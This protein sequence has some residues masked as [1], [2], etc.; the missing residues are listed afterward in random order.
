MNINRRAFALLAAGGALALATACGGTSD[1]AASG[2]A[3]EAATGPVTLNLWTWTGAPGGAAMQRAIDA[4]TKDHPN[5]TIKNTEIAQLDFKAKVP[6]ALNAGE[7]IDVLAVQ[8]NLFAD[9]IKDQLLPV[10]A[11]EKDLPAGTMAKFQPLSLEQNKK[12]YS[13]GQLYS[14]PFGLSG[15]AVGF[16][17]AALLKEVGVEPP[18]TFADMANLATVLK[19]KKPGV[20]VAVMPSGADSWFQDEFALT[21][22]GQQDKD[23]FNNV[24]YN[25]GPWN[26]PS[27]V[28]GLTALQKI[29]NDGGLDKNLIDVDYAKAEETFATGKAAM[30]FNGTWDSVLLSPAYREANKIA[31]TDV[32]ALPVPAVGDPATRSLRSFLDVTMGVPKTAKYPKEAADFIAYITTGAGVDAWAKDLGL[33][34]AVQGWNPPEGTLTSDAEKTGLKTIQDLIASP[35]GDRNNLSAFSAEVGKGVLKVIGGGNPTEAAQKMQDDL[36][37][38]KFS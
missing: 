37:S 28:Q 15:S 23:F 20:A 31:L 3:T 11:W 38:G 8:P 9:Q 2:S 22:V 14:V 34:P 4:Y 21:L 35:H 10:S 29:Y 26:T 32:G 12:L 25:N 33:I 6:L 16:Y 13:D 30:I 7:Q 1:P 18:Q 27:Y 36:D 5:V 17:N 19:E 24:R